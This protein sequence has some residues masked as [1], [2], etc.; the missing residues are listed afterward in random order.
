MGNRRE[1]RGNYVFE[2]GSW[3]ATGRTESQDV[4][5]GQRNCLPWR[6]PDLPGRLPRHGPLCPDQLQPDGWRPS[7]AVR[8]VHSLDARGRRLSDQHRRKDAGHQAAEHRGSSHP[9]HLDLID[10]ALIHPSPARTT[11]LFPGLSL[12]IESIVCYIKTGDK[13]NEFS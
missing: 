2:S 1:K 3:Y 13:R 12:T 11:T 8:R 5:G 6:L 7:S 4:G 10:P 9:G